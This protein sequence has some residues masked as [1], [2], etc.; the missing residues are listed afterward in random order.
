M[1]DIKKEEIIEAKNT[2]E[3]ETKKEDIPAIKN[4]ENDFKQNP[5]EK[6][7]FWQGSITR[8]F[9]VISLAI[10]V[11]AGTLL[12]YGVNK[13]AMKNIHHRPAGI[14]MRDDF[15]QNQRPHEQFRQGSQPG[16]NQI[17]PEMEN[18]N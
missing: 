8:K 5:S 17:P 13:I 10:A 3:P 7:N 16:N 14:E 15:R 18:S 12:N 9:F 4:A 11:L 2:E 1:E 6:Q